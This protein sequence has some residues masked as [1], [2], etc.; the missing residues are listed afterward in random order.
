MGMLLNF[1]GGKM[2]LSTMGKS[3]ILLSTLTIGTKVFADHG[4]LERKVQRKIS[5]IENILNQISRETYSMSEYELQ[6]VNDKLRFALKELK[7][8][9]DHD[10]GHGGGRYE[11]PP[12]NGGGTYPRPDRSY[13]PRRPLPPVEQLVTVT[14]TI[15]N[16]SFMIDASNA[17]DLAYKC[18]KQF[19]GRMQ[20]ADEAT[21][22]VSFGMRANLSTS[23]WWRSSGEVCAVIATKAAQ[24]GLPT[25]SVSNEITAVGS[26]ENITLAL[27]GFSLKDLHVQCT[28]TLS[29][30]RSSS[31]DE[32][33]VFNGVNIVKRKTSGWW[34]SSGEV[35]NLIVSNL[36]TL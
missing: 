14:G 7:T 17:S 23:G 32:L 16:M 22:S 30:S 6:A 27:K 12:Y 5:R 28:D 19:E 25:T 20:S 36:S 21:V 1:V 10:H 13:P 2:K 3:L 8:N 29:R 24:L 35:C 15:E 9:D 4:E 31:V 18:A 11:R 26:V 34:R 33:T